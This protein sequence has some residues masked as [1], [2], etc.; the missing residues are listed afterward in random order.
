MKDKILH[1]LIVLLLF[2]AMLSAASKE[3]KVLPTTS[4]FR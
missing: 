1:L 2:P 3:E 4:T